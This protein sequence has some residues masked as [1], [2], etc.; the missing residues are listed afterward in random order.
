MAT[1]T[2]L[3][4]GSQQAMAIDNAWDL[5]SSLVYYSEA[6]DRVTVH[7]AIAHLSG[8]I[9]DDDIATVNLVLDTMS[10]STPTGAIASN[11]SAISFTSASGAGGITAE[12]TV[13]DKVEFDDT[14]LAFSLDW[15]HSSSRL[16]RFKYGGSL[17]VEKDYQSYGAS[18]A[19]NQDTENRDKTYT[20][21]FAYAFDKI[22]RKTG[23]TPEPLSSTDDNSI[24]G[25]GERFVY[26]AI[27]GVS[28][29]LNK[30]T[31]AQLNYTLG[32]S[33]GYHTDPYKVISQADIVSQ[34]DPLIGEFSY[35]EI[36]RFYESRPT[37]RLRNALYTSMAHQ[38]GERN[39]V[40]HASYRYYWDD[41][42]IGAHT[43]DLTHRRPLNSRSYL[44]PHFRYHIQSAADFF[45]HHIPNDGNPLPEFASA[46]Y[47]LDDTTGITVGIEYGQTIGASSKLRVRFEYIDWQH[48]D[49]EYSETTA[50]VLQASYRKLF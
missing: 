37:S 2:L 39:E 33:D 4:G 41:W 25:D 30:R 35:G 8:D 15:E 26:D 42:G 48:E 5:D 36:D 21:G 47:R 3:A 28:K 49:A 11:S 46:D 18:I 27:V 1:C 7:K 9:S 34:S 24:L 19:M 43:I 20:F 12:G 45:M 40:I 13:P 44:E 23:G 32:Y 14:R 22:Y 50:M 17:S 6:D 16:R 29:V 10:G 38:Y 31:V